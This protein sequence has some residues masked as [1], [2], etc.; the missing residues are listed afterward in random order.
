[1]QGA[2]LELTRF[3]LHKVHSC[4]RGAQAEHVQVCLVKATNTP[5][6]DLHHSGCE[7]LNYEVFVSA[8]SAVRAPKQ[9]GNWFQ[10]KR[11]TGNLLPASLNS[12]PDV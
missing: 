7:V 1:M 3:V 10:H 12:K 2:E 5:C 11:V 6:K 9:H 8:E 4:L